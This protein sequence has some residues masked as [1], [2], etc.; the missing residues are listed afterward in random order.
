LN[1]LA[2]FF[3]VEF[4]ANRAPRNF[5]AACNGSAPSSAEA[6]PRART[7][8]TAQRAAEIFANNCVHA[9]G[10]PRALDTKGRRRSFL[11]A[12]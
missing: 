9:T 1:A 7:K 10:A 4:K 5:A 6:N 3:A 11:T 12:S 8:S 2:P